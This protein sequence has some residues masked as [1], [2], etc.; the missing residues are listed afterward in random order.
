MSRRAN[1]L[2]LA[3]GVSLALLVGVWPTSARGP[4]LLTGWLQTTGPGFVAAAAVLLAAWGPGA[5]LRQ[6]LLGPTLR[7]DRIGGALLD[8]ALGLA[9]LQS[10]G[11]A[12]GSVGVFGSWTARGIVAGGLGCA[13][14]AWTRRPPPAPRLP[15]ALAV[16]AGFC[17]LGLILPA[18]LQAGAPGTTSDELQ[19]HLRFVGGLLDTGRF[20]AHPDDP[21]TGLAQ[22]MHALLG[23]AHGLVGE[24]AL[25]PLALLLSLAGL[26]A[27]QRLAL[28]VAGPTAGIVYVPIALGAASLIRSLPVVGT[29]TPVMLFLAVALLLLVEQ[30][31]QRQPSDGRAALALGLIGGAAF[32]IKYTAATYFA[33]VWLVAA[34][35]AWRRDARAVALVAGSA[36]IPLVFAAPWL[37]KNLAM[38][39]HPLLPLAGFDIP[40]GLESAFR[41]NIGENYGGGAGFAAWLASPWDLFALGTEFDRRHFLGR[42]SPWPLLGVPF[43]VLALRDRGVRLLCAVSVLGLGLWA[44]PLRRVAYLLPLWPV[45]AA[46]TAAGLALAL[47]SWPTRTR[48]LAAGALGVAL[49]L[50]AVAEVSSAWVDGL[51]AAPVATGRQSPGAWIEQEVDSAAA[52]TWVREHVPRGEIVTS[53]FTWSLLPTGHSQRWAC[54]EECTAVRLELMKA[55]SG[56]AAAVRLSAMGSRWLLVREAAFPRERYANLTDA[57]FELSYALPL[58]VLDELTSLHGTLRFSDGLY[59]VYQLPSGQKTPGGS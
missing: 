56:H 43:L 2:I 15:G 24:R 20:S 29:D 13:A 16:A 31:A 45:I 3:T 39:A 38:G 32:S 34:L 54:A 1:A 57:E 9:V 14:L 11:V 48:R 59:S 44:G 35:L 52:W 37:L 58:R 23:L 26:V 47:Q 49:A 28:R 12:A 17:A 10:A 19:Y 21:L 46:T 25:R 7:D 36:L 55:G 50:T 8:L 27:G 51:R 18:L 53:A 5:L 33:P 30:G 4:H 22:G 6:R 42:L 40:A 41:F